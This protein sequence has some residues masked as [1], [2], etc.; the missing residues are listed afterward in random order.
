MSRIG[1]LNARHRTATASAAIQSTAISTTNRTR[2]SRAR[3]RTTLGVQLPAA[4]P[5]SVPMVQRQK[6]GREPVSAMSSAPTTN[7]TRAPTTTIDAART[8]DGAPSSHQRAAA[9]TT[10]LIA[11]DW[12]NA[13]ATTRS[14]PAQNHRLRNVHSTDAAS[15]SIMNSS[16]FAARSRG[17]PAAVRI[18]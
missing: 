2:E 4:Y 3:A 6:P 18:P 5:T 14:A 1:E 11:A 9:M 8:R 16:V 15:G 17:F 7:A 10:T 12:R 13:N